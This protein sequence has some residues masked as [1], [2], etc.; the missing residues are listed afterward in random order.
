VQIESGSFRWNA[1]LPPSLGGSNLAPSP[2]AL[3]LSSL[4]GCA[5][6]FIKDTLAPQLGIRVYA[7]DATASCESDS[8]GLLGIDAVAPDLC[9]LRLDISIESPDGEEAVQELL[10]VWKERC[11]IYL[12]L[13]N[14]MDLAVTARVVDWYA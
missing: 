9:N 4:A 12:A 11:P 10:G 13:L 7:V 5:V 8:R 3:L 6:A 14:P 2:T 1:D